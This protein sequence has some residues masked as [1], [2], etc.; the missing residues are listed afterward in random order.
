[1]D[2]VNKIGKTRAKFF[3]DDV[4][5]RDMVELS[6]VGDTS[7]AIVKVSPEWVAKF[8]REWAAY[9]QGQA[10]VTVTGTSL[11]EVPGVERDSLMRLKLAG[12]RTVEEL[13]GLDEAAAKSLGLGGVTFWKSAK[14]LLRSK[15]LEALE[16]LTAPPTEEQ[17]RGPGRPRKEPEAIA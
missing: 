3:K 6:A 1:M 15:Q 14:L 12:V 2:P 10:E 8:P 17:R 7:T 11:M 9:E 5:G 13:A 16:S 4:T